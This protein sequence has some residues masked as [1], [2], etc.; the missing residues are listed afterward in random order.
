MRGRAAGGFAAA[1]FLGQFLATFAIAYLARV[2]DFA[3]TFN[4]IAFA[5]AAV[6]CPRSS[7]NWLSA[8]LRLE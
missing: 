4:V 6:A 3:G 5:S 1:V 2:T 8:W 7:P